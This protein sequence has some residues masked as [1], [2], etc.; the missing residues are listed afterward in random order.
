M[1]N[2]EFT[3]FTARL[4]MTHGGD[5]VPATLFDKFTSAAA[6]TE[7]LRALNF[8]GITVA[9]SETARFIA[10][11]RRDGFY[12]RITANGYTSIPNVAN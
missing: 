3:A 5:Y 1:T 2:A 12:Y 6:M 11:G 4:I 9:P 10:H 7:A 8:T